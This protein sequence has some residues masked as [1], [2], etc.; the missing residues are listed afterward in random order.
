MYAHGDDSTTTERWK[1]SGAQELLEALIAE[2]GASAHNYHPSLSHYIASELGE[3]EEDW[4]CG[5]I[6]TDDTCS[7]YSYTCVR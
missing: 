1:D 4:D 6:N 3:Q 7:K 5:D 2:F